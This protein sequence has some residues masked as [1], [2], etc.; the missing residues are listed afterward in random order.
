[1]RFCTQNAGLTVAYFDVLCGSSD[2]V[3]GLSAIVCCVDRKLCCNSELLCDLESPAVEDYKQFRAS[4]ARMRVRR[5]E[6]IMG[7]S[8]LCA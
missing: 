6:M 2:A 1:M 7:N 8:A 5:D 4:P 3:R